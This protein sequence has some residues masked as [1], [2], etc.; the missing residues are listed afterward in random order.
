MAAVAFD[1]SAYIEWIKG[2]FGVT[3]SDA[4]LQRAEYLGG[5]RIPLNI[6]QI[7]QTSSTDT[8]SPQGNTAGFSCTISQDSMFT[9]SFE[10]HGVLMGLVVIRTDHTYQQGLNKMWTRKKWVDYYNPFF[11]NLSEQAVLNENLYLQGTTAD[12]EAFGYQE[13]WAEYRYKEN[14][15]TGYMRSNATGSLDVWHFADDYNSQPYLSQEWIEETTANVD[16]TIAVTSQLTHQ[17]IADFFFK[18]YYTRC[19]PVYSIPGLIDHV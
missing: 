10:E 11:A 8:V 9:K 1:R 2:V 7:L 3:S 12:K 17:F 16:R 13:A 19:M 18:A 14:R 5:Q 6:D 15:V 4:R